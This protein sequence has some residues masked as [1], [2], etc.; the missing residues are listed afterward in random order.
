MEESEWEQLTC[1]LLLRRGPQLDH[2]TWRPHMSWPP[3]ASSGYSAI[4]LSS[5]RCENRHFTYECTPVSWLEW[6]VGS[7]RFVKTAEEK[8]HDVNN[9]GVPENAVQSSNATNTPTTINSIPNVPVSNRFEP[10]STE[11]EDEPDETIVT[12]QPPPIKIK[13]I[14]NFQT[15][16][17]NLRRNTTDLLTP[18]L[19][20]KNYTTRLTHRQRVLKLHITTQHH[21][22]QLLKQRV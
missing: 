14:T 17:T 15:L 13:G 16:C 6:T 4:D 22:S 19:S 20:R 3:A 1:I 8:E 12:H 10:L 21:N 7:G 18:S 5:V 2:P 9:T 11:M